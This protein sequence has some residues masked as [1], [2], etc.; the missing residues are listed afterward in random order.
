MIVIAHRGASGHAPEHTF[1]AWDLA[2]QFGADYLEQDLQMT[3]DGVLVVMHD[4]TLDRTIHKGG[5]PATG[6]VIDHTMAEL[7]EMEAGSWYG[8]GF[9]GQPVPTLA[10]V[11]KRYPDAN[12]YI[13]TKKPEEAPGMEE[14]L[15]KMLG[16]YDLL[17]DAR[18]KWRVL[19]QSFS[20]ASLRKMRAAEPDL[21]Y[22]QLLDRG[23][24]EPSDLPRIAGYAVGIGLHHSDVDNALVEAAHAACLHV[25]PYTVDAAD[26]MKRLMNLGVDG[27]FTNLPDRLLGLPPRDAKR[28]LARLEEAARANRLCREQ[29]RQEI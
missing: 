21:P 24:Y 26:E 3:K 5:T 2:S 23:W 18:E 17:D 9:A 12:F 10:E 14:A 28:G 1:A 19:I 25:H 29:T 7:R 22:I 4:E 13:E 20:E 11:L 6:R 8:P 15:L 16:A 27:I